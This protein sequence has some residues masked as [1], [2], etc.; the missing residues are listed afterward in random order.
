M[1][2]TLMRKSQRTLRMSSPKTREP[3]SLSPPR[4]E[5]HHQKLTRKLLCATNQCPKCNFPSLMV[6]IQRFGGI[7]VKAILNC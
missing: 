4:K 2:T 1:K 6:K 3:T 5:S 7:I